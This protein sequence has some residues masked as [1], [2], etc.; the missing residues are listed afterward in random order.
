[1]SALL[2]NSTLEAVF[3]PFPKVVASNLDL[4]VGPRTK[5]WSEPSLVEKSAS[6]A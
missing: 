1:M 5:V 2:R 3:R 6:L 4:Q